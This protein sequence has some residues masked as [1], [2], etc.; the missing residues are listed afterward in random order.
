MRSQQIVRKP[1]AVRPRSARTVRQRLYIRFPQLGQAFARAV[2][3]LPPRSR[4]RQAMISRAFEFATDALNRRDM[5]AALIAYRPDRELYPPP[6]WV[7][8]G[9]V[10]S[11]YRGPDGFRRYISELDDVWGGNLRVEP[12]ELI[13][14]G[15]RLVMLAGLSSRAEA[16]GLALS[17][18]YA[19]VMTLRAGEV[20]RQVDYTS[21]TDALEAAGLPQRVG[22]GRGYAVARHA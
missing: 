12:A 11:C 19:T 22:H 18:E 10:E 8:A 5:D 7:E 14:L 17:S 1:L 16:S 3:A 2:D 20:V 4:L 13:D 6:E 9:F 15:D 21:H